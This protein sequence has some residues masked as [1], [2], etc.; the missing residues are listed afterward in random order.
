MSKSG[1]HF[2]ARLHPSN[3]YEDRAIEVLE[4]LLRNGFKKRQIFTD[5]LLRLDGVTPEMF[6]RDGTA[7]HDAKYILD[8]IE[9]MLDELW[10]EMR[11]MLEDVRVN[12]SQ[13]IQ[14]IHDDI[15]DSNIGDREYAKNMINAYRQRMRG[16]DDGA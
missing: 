7:S 4:R 15:G 2:S 8:N 3:E 6:N 9:G 11:H 5:A 12:G 16:G 13:V 14:E 10:S 1:V